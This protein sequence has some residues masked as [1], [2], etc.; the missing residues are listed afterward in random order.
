MIILAIDTSSTTVSACLITEDK[1]LSE[2]YLNQKNNHSE[3][4]MPIIDNLLKMCDMQLDD[5]DYLACSNGP[6]S[7]TGLRVGISTI[8]G[9]AF[10]LN[11]KIIAISTLEV[12]AYNIFSTNN[13]V[14]PMIDAKSNSI[15]TGVYKNGKSILADNIMSIEEILKYIKDSGENPIFLGDGAIKYKNVISENFSDKNIAPIN[16][17]MPK[18]SSI[19]ELAINRIREQ[20]LV[21]C[22][23]LE[24]NYIKK[25]QAQIELE[26]KLRCN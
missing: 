14:V 16:L 18:S 1:I 26:E 24:I 11:K 20:N 15:F 5:V 2:I 21:D 10:A 9:I 6:G 23:N 3:T 17:I 12:L 8:K 13:V 4:I 22:R 25:P 19:G 7:F